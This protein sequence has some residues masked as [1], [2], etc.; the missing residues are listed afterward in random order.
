MPL[1][2]VDVSQRDQVEKLFQDILSAFGTLHILVNNAGVMD[3]FDPAG[4]LDPVLWDHVMAMDLTTSFLLSR[5]AIQDFLAQ[6]APDEYILNIASMASK[7]GLAAG[8]SY[9]T[10]RHRLVGLT[11]NNSS[12][13]ANKRIRCNAL[14]GGMST[15]V[16]DAFHAGINVRDS[17]NS[18]IMNALKCQLARLRVQSA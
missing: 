7:V 1:L 11:K 13:Y 2:H 4:D 12:F 10:S 16:T 17:K 9:T 8:T 14:M 3:R 18:G 5:V 6:Q 15:N